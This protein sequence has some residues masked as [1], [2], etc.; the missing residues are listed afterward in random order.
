M[1]R[2]SLVIL[3]LS[4]VSALHDLSAHAACAGD[5]PIASARSFYVEH[6]EFSL[7]SP[8][9]IKQFV[10]PQLFAALDKEFKCAQG[11]VCAL[12]ADPWT[13]AQDGDIKNPLKFTL[14][15]NSGVLAKVQMTYTFA[16]DK[17]RRRLQSATLLLQREPAS[18]CWLV[19][20]LIGP[21]GASLVATIE[22]WHKEFGRGF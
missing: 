11:E 14:I 15:S 22:K 1:T 4:F 16:L 3:V 20:D 21:R 8:S 10:S 12:E 7:E 5:D 13:D 17:K 2:P 19:A 6:R 18:N 9:K